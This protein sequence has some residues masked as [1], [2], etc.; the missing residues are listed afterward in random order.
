MSESLWGK[1]DYE[2]PKNAYDLLRGTPAATGGDVGEPPVADEPPK[3]AI[4]T[5][6]ATPHDAVL[7]ELQNTYPNIDLSAGISPSLAEPTEGLDGR[8]LGDNLGLPEDERTYMPEELREP[9]TGAV[10]GA[11]GPGSQRGMKEFSLRNQDM[12]T[13]LSKVLDLQS[14][15][16]KLHI[17]MEGITAK[18]GAGNRQAAAR[19]TKM[20]WDL[21]E[22]RRMNTRQ[23]TL[24]AGKPKTDAEEM[25][26]G[27]EEDEEAQKRKAREAE[28]ANLATKFEGRKE[29][30]DAIMDKLGD[31]S[32]ALAEFHSLPDS[33]QPQSQSED[34]HAFANWLSESPKSMASHLE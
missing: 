26:V 2:V 4:T 23:D 24:P 21:D 8:P 25:D 16:A 10:L 19:G 3:R 34:K 32:K 33:T 28:F 27:A 13:R 1:P 18:G 20:T 5:A 11:V 17:D 7:L 30:V 22:R 9:F 12:W 29:K 14:E 31:L 15:I 6:I